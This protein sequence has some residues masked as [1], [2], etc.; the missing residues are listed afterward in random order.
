MLRAE[1]EDETASA[2]CVVI[3]ARLRPE[4]R[5]TIAQLRQDRPTTVVFVGLP[6]DDEAPWVDLVVPAGTDWR[7]PMPSRSTLEWAAIALG[8]VVQSVWLG[9]L[10]SAFSGAGWPPLSAFA[11]AVVL[12]AAA[13]TRWTAPDPRRLRRGRWLL[14]ALVLVAAAALFAAGRGWTLDFVAWQLARDAVYAAAAAGLG[15]RLGRGDDVPGQAFARAARAFGA[16]IAVLVLAGVTATPLPG[17][18]AAVA[19]AVVAGG[20]YIAVVRYRALSDVVTAEDRLP[21]WPWLLSVTSVIAAV[22]VVTG[23]VR[24]LWRQSRA[25]RGR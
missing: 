18:V 9:V 23:L 14:V 20:L 25:L 15:I 11:A 4:V 3:T 19:T 8:A 10:A 17:Q 16:L 5:S 6:D 13:A 7:A 22:L 1:L 24:R 21:L 12:A 2:E